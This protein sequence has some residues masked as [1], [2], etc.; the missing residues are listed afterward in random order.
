M[1]SGEPE[2]TERVAHFHGFVSEMIVA[3]MRG[4]SA[5]SLEE[6]AQGEDE[7]QLSA[8]L[9]Q[10]WFAALVGWA[11]GLHPEEEVVSQ[12]RRA[13]EILMRG[14]GMEG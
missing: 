6:Q 10:I 9:Q 5:P 4:A 11:G 2:L 1:A 3:A 14:M 13:A 12:V 8:I 7:E